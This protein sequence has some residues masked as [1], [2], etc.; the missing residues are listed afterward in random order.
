MVILAVFVLAFALALTKVYQSAAVG[1]TEAA[2]LRTFP[3]TLRMLF[4]LI[5]T[6]GG[7]QHS[8]VVNGQHSD[9]ITAMGQNLF[10]LYMTIVVVLL[11]NLLIA[12]FSMTFSAVKD[13]TDQEWKF[14]RARLLRQFE[15][16]SAVPPPLNII[17]AP[18]MRVC[19]VLGV[20]IVPVAVENQSELAEDRIHL[21]K[22]YRKLA[23][24]LAASND[25]VSSP[26][27]EMQALRHEVAQLRADVSS[28]LSRK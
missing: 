13:N 24:R 25:S 17:I 20:C 1:N 12:A 23:S 16:A 14:L 18:L 22:L 4:F 11:L 6:L 2:D 9:A 21:Q 27:S 19:N 5:F 8:F 28:L 26:G 15:Q 3:G 10:G 7:D